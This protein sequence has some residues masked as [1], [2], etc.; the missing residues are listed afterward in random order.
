MN[1]AAAAVARAVKFGDAAAERA[2][3]AELARTVLTEWVAKMVDTGVMLSSEQ[4]A[5]IHELIESITEAPGPVTTARVAIQTVEEGSPD[6]TCDRCGASGA[7]VRGWVDPS[8][9]PS[10]VVELVCITCGERHPFNTPE[11]AWS[12]A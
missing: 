8:R 12:S 4:A 6:R 2:A 11:E 3:R 1:S 10:M 7:L 9:T 5:E